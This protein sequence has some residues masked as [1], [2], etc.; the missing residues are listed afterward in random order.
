MPSLT[1]RIA[2]GVEYFGFN[3]SGWQSQQQSSSVQDHIETAISTVAN[4]PIRIFASGRTDA[5]VHATCQVFHFDTTSNR[6][7]S[8]WLLGVNSKLP[9][10]INII[11][12]KGVVQEFDARYSAISRTYQYLIV[13]QKINDVFLINHAL[14]VPYN[15]DIN[16][17]Q[18]AAR[19]F[20][21]EHDFTSFRSSSCQARS[22]TR[23]IS[24]LNIK[25]SN[26]R[27]LIQ[28]TA[29]AFLQHMVR[30]IVGTL[31]D[32]GEG[33]LSPESIP[34]ILDSKDRIKSGKTASSSGLYL[35][36]IDYPGKF[37][38]PHSE[39]KVRLESYLS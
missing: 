28:C 18:Q 35:V 8:E 9:D 32:I 17:M 21:G 7:S 26:Q 11:W 16:L 24:T 3:Y 5:G 20:H 34:I 6:T 36:G 10:D 15:L 14:W 19:H 38:L 23:T 39:F 33:V 37:Q 29:N 25:Q 22:P 4:E 2:C 31:I 12:V 30:N 13:N 1:K 27:I